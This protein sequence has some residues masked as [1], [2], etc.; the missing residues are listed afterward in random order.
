MYKYFVL[1]YHVLEFS[2]VQCVLADVGPSVYHSM[3]YEYNVLER[4]DAPL[5]S[6]DSITKKRTANSIIMAGI[7]KYQL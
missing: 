1:Q 2:A 4:N 5:L 7:Y 3:T 6:N